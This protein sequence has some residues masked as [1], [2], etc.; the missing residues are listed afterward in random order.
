M[1]LV[2]LA[3]KVWQF[4]RIVEAFLPDVHAVAQLH[5]SQNC[6]QAQA[7]SHLSQVDT[8]TCKVLEVNGVTAEYYAMQWPPS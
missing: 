4:D 3:R 6:Q 8:V 2:L 1:K 7:V 5:L